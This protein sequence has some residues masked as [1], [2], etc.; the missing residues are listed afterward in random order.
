[1][2]NHYCCKSGKDKQSDKS[3]IPKP[4]KHKP[5]SPEHR[6]PSISDSHYLKGN[7]AFKNSNKKAS[8]HRPDGSKQNQ[9][10]P[11]C[12]LSPL[13]NQKEPSSLYNISAE[14]AN[15]MAKKV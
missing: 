2:G 4:E 13:L 14:K 12:L 5:E 9:Q 10:D 1:M 15:K 7:S 3:L 8:N 11:E 6:G